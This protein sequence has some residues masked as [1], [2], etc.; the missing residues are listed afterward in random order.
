[1][2]EEPWD[3]EQDDKIKMRNLVVN[4]YCLLSS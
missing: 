1:M 2:K 3:T 4:G